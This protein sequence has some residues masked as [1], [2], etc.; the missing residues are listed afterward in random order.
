MQQ[1]TLTPFTNHTWMSSFVF[2]KTELH[3]YLKLTM[4]TGNL[5]GISVST[6]SAWLNPK[7]PCPS[8]QA[9]CTFRTANTTPLHWA[10]SHTNTPGPFTFLHI[11][12][13]QTL[14]FNAPILPFLSN[15]GSLV[16]SLINALPSPP[17]ALYS[18]KFTIDG[19]QISLQV[20]DTPFVSLEV[21]QLLCAFY[22]TSASCFVAST[23]ICN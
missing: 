8:P 19:E 13:L 5:N 11:L 21:K 15:F 17:G 23:S 14:N 6:L 3:L 2:I 16:Q 7:G 1:E 12:N 10:N 18:R 20:Q 9:A 4:W 22:H